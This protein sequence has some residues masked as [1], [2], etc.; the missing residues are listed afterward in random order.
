[1]WK[2]EESTCKAC[3]TIVLGREICKFVAFS[4][5]SS[6]WLL[7]VPNRLLQLTITWYKIRHAGAQV[8][9]YSRTGTS[10]QRQKTSFTG[11]GLFVLM[12]KCGNNN[13]LALQHGGFC[14]TWSLVAKRPIVQ[15]QRAIIYKNSGEVLANYIENAL[16]NIL[17]LWNLLSFPPNVVNLG[18][19]LSS[20]RIFGRG[21]WKTYYVP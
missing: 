15:Q 16:W 3:K 18:K 11:S 20:Q 19:N 10:K 17:S 4:L 8:H 13:K 6:S 5:P 9:Y 1:M 7:K 14:T 2:N 21:Q 12:S